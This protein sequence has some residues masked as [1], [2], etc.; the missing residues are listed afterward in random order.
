MKCDRGVS[1]SARSRSLAYVGR[2]HN[3]GMGQAAG[4]AEVGKEQPQCRRTGV[5]L[6]RGEEPVGG[7]QGDRML[8]RQRLLRCTS[9][10]SVARKKAPPP[11]L[12]P[13]VKSL[14]RQA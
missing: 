4:A 14:I 1:D 9:T 13:N 10:T 2:S 5:R 11:E 7:G 12:W 8:Q 6:C 3:A